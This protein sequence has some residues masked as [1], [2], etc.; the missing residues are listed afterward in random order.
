M[1]YSQSFHLIENSMQ[2]LF[3]ILDKSTFDNYSHSTSYQRKY[4][5]SNTHEKNTFT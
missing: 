1:Y 4:F 3:I 2:T 5:L